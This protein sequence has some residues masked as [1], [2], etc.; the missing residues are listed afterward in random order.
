MCPSETLLVGAHRSATQ[1]REA[2]P[3]ANVLVQRLE[4]AEVVRA[5][6]PCCRT[7]EGWDPEAMAFPSCWAA[8]L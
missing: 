2:M 4:S 8:V 1:V 7:A 3:A 6:L 5:L